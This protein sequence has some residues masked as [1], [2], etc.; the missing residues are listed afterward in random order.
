MLLL[1]VYLHDLIKDEAT[2]IEQTPLANSKEEHR[3]LFFEQYKEQASIV[4]KKM[5]VKLSFML[6]N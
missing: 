2:L 5:E 4:L 6:L 3:S 1:W